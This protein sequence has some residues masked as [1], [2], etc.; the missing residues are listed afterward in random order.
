MTRELCIDGTSIHDGSDCYVIAEIG[1][2]HQGSLEQCK[3]MFDVAK[4]CGANAVKLQKRDNRTLYTKAMYDSPYVH[5]N[6]YAPTYGTH[7]EKLEFGRS[8]Y[9][10]LIRH[11]KT[12]GITFFSTAFDIPSADFL[13]KLDMPAYK[14]ASGDLTNIPLL[15]HVAK[16]G[17]PIIISTGGGTMEDVVRAYYTIM[18]LNRQLSILQCTSG[19]PAEFEEL[20][21]K[22]IESF[23]ERFPETVVG[24]SS[25]D[26]GIAMALVGYVM[27]AR[28]VEKHFTLNRAAKG[29]DHA[30][31]LT[32]EGLH[33]MIR[34]LHRAHIAM[35][36]GVKRCYESEQAP[37]FKMAKKLVAARDLPTG[38][39]LSEAD[40]AL[41]SPSDGLPAFEFD[42][43][44][45]MRLKAPL[46]TDDNILYEA[47][48]QVAAPRQAAAR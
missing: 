22:V 23:R 46:K 31:S 40:V 2:N 44:L 9:E 3:K 26:N 10:E 41:K 5:R 17:K 7:R 15:R 47:L 6:S 27:G 1:H 42:N 25:H 16:I 11:A 24:L 35:G 19:Y 8:E 32:P 4:E 20:N 34:D 33:R 28:I 14:I 39:V 13:A 30:F 18:P 36:D 29:T 38:H 48:E 12:I 45:G 43:V 37:L 21:L